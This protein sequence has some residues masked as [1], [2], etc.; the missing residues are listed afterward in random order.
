MSEENTNI[1]DFD[2]DMICEYFS[3][4]DRQGPGSPEVTRRALGFVGGLDGDS[5][6]A[7]LGCGTG[8]QTMVLGQHAPGHITGLDLFPAFIELFNKNAA[9]QGLG[10]RV[11]GVVGSMEELPF[12]KGELDLIWSE[13]AIYNMGFER[14]LSAWRD[15]LKPGG[16]VAVTE[17]SW[18]TP[19]R[20]EEIERFWMDAYPEIGTVS[21][22]VAGMEKTGYLPLAAFIIPENCWTD[23]FYT[24]QEKTRED[25]LKEHAGNRAA[26]AFVE[27][28]AHEAR[29]Y[30]MYKEYYG[31][32]FY[33]GKKIGK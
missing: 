2:L 29:M 3:A 4:L 30:D 25:F 13:G 10:D 22:K 28:M 27:Y 24:P 16:Y 9:A 33:I 1:H 5:R 15:H 31:Y 8:G 23:H 20:P 11:K 6:I 14:G 32:V 21:A 17:A 19:G 26:E 18:F 7:D 12:G